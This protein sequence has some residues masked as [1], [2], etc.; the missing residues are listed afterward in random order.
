MEIYQTREG[1]DCVF[2]EN[3]DGSQTS[4]LKSFYDAQQ[5]ALPK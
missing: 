5:A 1:V 2:I 4:M 3:P